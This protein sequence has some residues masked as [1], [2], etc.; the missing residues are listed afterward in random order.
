M[1]DQRILPI[2]LSGKMDR[3]ALDDSTNALARIDPRKIR[4]AV[5]WQTQL[6]EVLKVSNVTVK[7]DWRMAP[8]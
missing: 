2:F 3:V 7:R 8:T 4:N 6:A 1:E 5:L